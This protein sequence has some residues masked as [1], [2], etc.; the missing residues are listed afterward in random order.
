MRWRTKPA[1]PK[2]GDTV[3]ISTFLFRPL[4]IGSEYR[5]LE[6]ADV[7]LEAY[8]K[9]DIFTG[10]PAIFWRPVAFVDRSDEGKN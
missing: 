3:V 5:W 7:R 6:T 1:D 10:Y 4:K 8:K 9:V 2:E